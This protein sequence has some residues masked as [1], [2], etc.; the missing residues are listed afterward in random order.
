MPTDS[1]RCG[2]TVEGRDGTAVSRRSGR[3]RQSTRR[4][5]TSFP[6]P[7]SPPY[8]DGT[9]AFSHNGAVSGWPGSLADLAAE[10]PAVELLKMPAPTDAALLWTVLRHRLKSKPAEAAVTSL[11]HD[12]A[13]AAPDSRLNLLFG[14]GQELWA[15]AW[16]HTLYTRVDESRALIVSEPSDRS[17]DWE[18]VPDRHIV[19]ARPGHLT[20]TPIPMGEQ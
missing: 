13:A 6:D 3:T 7:F 2:G 12:V 11:V 9:Y 4:C 15:T 14:D 20:V 8:V 5:P 18:Q 16:G 19:C 17:P 10:V 1:A